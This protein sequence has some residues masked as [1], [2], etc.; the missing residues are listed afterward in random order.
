MM[1][2]LSFK[3]AEV[4]GP[5]DLILQLI[6]KHK[7]NIMDIDISALLAQ[8]LHKIEEWKEQNME[9]ASEFLQMASRLVYMKS[10]SLLPRHEELEELKKELTGQLIEYSLCKQMSVLLADLFIG[11]DVFVKRPEELPADTAYTR[12]HS[13]LELLTA[14]QG[15]AG[16]YMRRMPPDAAAFEPL[17]T[18]RVVSVSSKLTLILTRLYEHKRMYFSALYKESESRS[19]LVATFLAVLELVKAN[20]AYVEE[21]E[22]G[23]EE[24]L[25]SSL[26]SAEELEESLQAIK[27]GEEVEM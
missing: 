7:L 3:V 1:E 26:H 23:G 21:D 6:A 22:E 18:R 15:I 16:K 25:V 5:L 20:R 12:E 4:E 14:Y 9:I 19:D 8:Y 10:V 2:Q 27:A 13:I 11:D 17:V 24:R